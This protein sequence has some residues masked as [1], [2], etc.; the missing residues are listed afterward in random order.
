MASTKPGAI[1]GANQAFYEN[2]SKPAVGAAVDM[3]LGLGDLAQMGARYLGNRAGFDAGE[4]TPAAP[5]V[6]EALGVEG[7]DPYALGS[8]ATQV[9]PFAAAGRTAVSAPTVARQF[10]TMFP[11]LGRESGAYVGGET[12]A[13]TARE[14]MPGST[15]A[16]LLAG[17]A[18]GMGGGFGGS[19]LDA[20]TMS[21]I[22][23]PTGDE[24]PAGSAASM[25]DEGA[26]PDL[27]VVNPDAKGHALPS[28]LLVEGTGEKA[29]NPVTQEFTP[30]NKAQNFVNI[31]AVEAQ[32]PAALMS[33]ENWLKAEEQA[34]GGD[35]L[36]APPETA[37][38]YA[39]E[40]E[41]LAATLGRLSPDMKKSVDE[42][43]SYVSEI[44]NLYNSRIAPPAMTGRLF[45][46]GILSR[47]VGPAPQEG[48][49]LD[50][51]NNATPFI[52]KAVKGQFTEA[53]I[54]AWKQMVKRSLP[55]G[56][57]GKS[58]TM[59]S[60][61]AG[62]LL[63]QLG[64]S[65]D[66]NPPPVIKLHEILS[67]PLRTGREFRREFFKLTQSP[68]IDNKVVSFIGLAAGKPDML[69]MDRIQSRNLW[70][71]GRYGGKNIYDGINKG[72]LNGILGGP[73]GVMVTEM[74]EDGLSDSVQ[75]AYAMIGRPED[76][77]LSRMHWETWLIGSS[78]PVSHS[79]LQAV[80]S[81]EAIGQ[82][83]TEGKRNTYS[84]NMTYRQTINGPIVEYPLSTGEIVRMTPTRQKEFEKFIGNEK[85]R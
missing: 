81:G 36:P 26:G 82:S 46:W 34:F 79:T 75:R 21:R 43:L 30:Q 65:I 44:K 70:D 80:R 23:A 9:L 52:D 69:V 53:D 39:Q 54:D 35:Y 45:L 85:M 33:R 25:L 13:A 8:I 78:K 63:Y 31:D 58:S 19:A 76:A 67:D 77:S 84:S 28:L 66:G 51:L 57:P 17:V 6:R 27:V 49:F 22:D 15:A 4:F 7:Y 38:K 3:T 20:P 24:P 11:N 72:G 16:E 83:V 50:L 73:R 18:G 37:I 41:T 64:R 1:H 60:N 32:N 2:I 47:G 14:V 10:D 56:S 29:V 48:A 74:M 68:G 62:N 40:P 71:D 12:A 61:A 5:R 55:E 42:G 59:N